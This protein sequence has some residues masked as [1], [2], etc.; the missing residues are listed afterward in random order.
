MCLSQDLLTQHRGQRENGHTFCGSLSPSLVTFPCCDK[1]VSKAV[2]Q[3]GLLGSKRFPREK[4]P[5][6][7]D[8]RVDGRDGGRSRLAVFMHGKEKGGCDCSLVTFP[9]G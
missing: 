2:Q 3:R 1:V 6:A 7:G 8:L 4:R 9:F 5:R